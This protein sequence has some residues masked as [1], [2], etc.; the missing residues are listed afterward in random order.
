MGKNKKK[1]NKNNVEDGKEVKDDMN[2]AVESK[3]ANGWFNL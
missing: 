1:A 3:F 2:P